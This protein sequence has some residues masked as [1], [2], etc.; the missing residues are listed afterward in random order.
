MIR[1]LPTILAHDEVA[2]Q[3]RLSEVR[4]FL[5][6]PEVPMVQIDILD[7]HFLPDP[8]TFATPAF[9]AALQPPVP[10][11][12]HLMVSD[13]LTVIPAWLEAGAQ[14][15]FFHIEAVTDL[16]AAIQKA[17]SF[18][19]KQLGIALS[20]ETPLEAVFPVAT[21]VD[22]VLLMGV[23][24][25]ASGRAFVPET[26]ERIRRLKEAI[27]GILIEV[28]GGVRPG[29]TAA[30]VQAGAEDLAVGSYFSAGSPVVQLASLNADVRR[31][32]DL[33]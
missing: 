12:V 31:L 26:V 8:P 33:Q 25:G 18:G 15:V 19:V 30:L 6:H 2:F 17:R 13:P 23:H 3:A 5:K 21:A 1:F 7:G 10:F 22:A 20:P 24:P 11:E 16:P 9:V 27:P 28:D 32:Q 14:R 4:P 29:I